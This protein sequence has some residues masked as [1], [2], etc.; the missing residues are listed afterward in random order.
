VCR[1]LY[2]KVSFLSVAR[3][4]LSRL[5]CLLSIGPRLWLISR[6]ADSCCGSAR[7]SFCL[8]RRTERT[9]AVVRAVFGKVIGC[10][11][12][13]SVARSSLWIAYSMSSVEDNCCIN[14]AVD[15]ARLCSSFMNVPLVLLEFMH[16]RRRHQTVRRRRVSFR[17][18]RY[19]P[20]P[21]VRC[22]I[23]SCLVGVVVAVDSA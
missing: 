3:S 12:D 17:R 2:L 18:C 15:V 9:S 23:S 5:P 8:R 20:C 22:H 10:R 14:F 4:R 13:G 11:R 7:V 6:D 21:L 16:R 1:G 19:L